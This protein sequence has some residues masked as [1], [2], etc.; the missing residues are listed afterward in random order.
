MSNYSN[1]RKKSE[2][3]NK[4]REAP[5]NFQGEKVLLLEEQVLAEVRELLH[6]LIQLFL[7]RKLKRR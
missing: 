6:N 7:L 4:E 3:N 1:S 5:N 2:K